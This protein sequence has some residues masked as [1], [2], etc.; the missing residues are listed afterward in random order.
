MEKKAWITYPLLAIVLGVLVFAGSL[1]PL[2][3]IDGIGSNGLM[4]FFHGV[5]FLIFSFVLFKALRHYM[6][7]S[8]A[9]WCLVLA[10]LV[11]LLSESV[12]LMI[13]YRTFSGHDLLADLAGIVAGTVLGLL[14]TK[15]NADD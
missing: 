8:A 9:M 14:L 5:E 13:D 12:Q 6:I 3:S 2:D 11:A 1:I 4:T 15:R 7:D 10:A